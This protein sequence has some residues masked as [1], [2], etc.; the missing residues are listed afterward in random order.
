LKTIFNVEDI[1]DVTRYELTDDDWDNIE[2]ISRNRYKKWEWNYG[3]S[4]SY[5]VKFS[6]KFPSGLLDV[7]LQ[8]KKGMIENCKIYGDFFGLGNV[9]KIESLLVG[10]RHKRKDVEE[11]LEDI[12]VTYYLGKITKEDF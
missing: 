8:V 11:A 7:R 2:D 1:E 9:E 6:H 3:K 10:C 5:N 12:D 4:P